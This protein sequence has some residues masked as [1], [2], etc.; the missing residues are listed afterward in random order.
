LAGIWSDRQAA[1]GST[2]PSAASAASQ[3]DLVR[4]PWLQMSQSHAQR[5]ML[6]MI[7]GRRRAQRTTQHRARIFRHL[8]LHGE[9]PGPYS[10]VA[11]ILIPAWQKPWLSSRHAKR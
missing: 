1:A 7:A 10:S 9:S 6:A 8:G 5:F 3:E 4:H 2:T 11:T